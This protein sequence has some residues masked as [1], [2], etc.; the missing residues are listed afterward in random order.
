M[1]DV[2]FSKHCEILH[3]HSDSLCMIRQRNDAKYMYTS[4]EHGYCVPG[5]RG[6]TPAIAYTLYNLNR[7]G[8]TLKLISRLTY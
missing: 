7:K 3:L 8:F 5:F 1:V 4:R 2:R 6:N